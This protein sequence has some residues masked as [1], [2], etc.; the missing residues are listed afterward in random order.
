MILFRNVFE[1]VCAGV[2]PEGAGLR[3]LRLVSGGG[4]GGNTCAVGRGRIPR[5]GADLPG[6]IAR[7]EHDGAQEITTMK[8]SCVVE[9]S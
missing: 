1:A 5:S 9:E 8:L 4:R 7:V 6:I 2:D 3:N